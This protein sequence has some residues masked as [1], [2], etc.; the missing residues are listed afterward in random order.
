VQFAGDAA[1]DVAVACI[2][3]TSARAA[4]KLGLQRIFY[5]EEPSL[6]NFVG[7][8]LEALASVRSETS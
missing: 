8:I 2:G 3:S 1:K 6:D 5:P 4:E 7:S